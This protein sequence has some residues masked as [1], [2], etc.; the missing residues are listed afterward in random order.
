MRARIWNGSP[1]FAVELVILGVRFGSVCLSLL[2]AG[3]AIAVVIGLLAPGLPGAIAAGVSAAVALVVTM[4]V[5][6]W[7]H[8]VDR[9]H[10]LTEP[11]IVGALISGARNRTWINL[12]TT[13]E[14]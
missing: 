9:N 14:D 6:Y 7:L 1:K 3:L 12:D 2:G 4:Q 13:L 10:T 11:L 8:A 5:A